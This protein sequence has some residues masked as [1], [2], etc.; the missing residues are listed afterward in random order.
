MTSWCIFVSSG[1]SLWN[2]SI[3]FHEQAPKTICNPTK[4][5]SV[6][7]YLRRSRVAHS[8]KDLEKHLPS[9]ASINGM[10]VKGPSAAP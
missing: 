6:V 5:A 8:I 9:V 3:S 4:L 10:Q 1:H 2:S 7:T